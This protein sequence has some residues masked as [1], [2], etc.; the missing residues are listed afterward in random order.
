MNSLEAQKFQSRH[1]CAV[2]GSQPQLYILP[3]KELAPDGKTQEWGYIV[4][5]QNQEHQGFTRV[6]GYTEAWRRGETIPLHIANQIE[7]KERRKMT[8]ELGDETTRELETYVGRQLLTQEQVAIILRSIWP[9]APALEVAKAALICHMYR[10][11]PLMGHLYLLPFKDKETGEVTWA[12]V[13]GITATRLIVSRKHRYSYIT[14]P[15][16]M[17]EQEQREI[18][19]EVDEK[20]YWAITVLQDENG[21]HAPGY[22]NWPKDQKPYGENKGNTGQNMAMIRSE[23][24]SF[25][26]LAPGDMPTDI[27]VGPIELLPA[28]RA[29]EQPKP[30]QVV[31]GKAKP[32]APPVGD[33]AITPAQVTKLWTEAGSRGYD[34]EQVHAAIKARYG[35]ETVSRLTKAQAADFIDQLVKGVNIMA[36]VTTAL[37]GQAELR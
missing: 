23:R 3:E 20:H 28:L 8:Q 18:R 22:G 14:G 26:R 7:Q 32:A 4:R 33:A 34:K 12:A 24:N 15:R 21:N 16:M 31:E 11:N 29:P 5:C 36:G 9:A 25:D 6:M 13:L 1:M 2:C 17:T 27:E 37:P 35:V 10:L 19:G 30:P